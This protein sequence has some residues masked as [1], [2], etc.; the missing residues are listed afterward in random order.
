M[1][2]GLVVNWRRGRSV[3]PSW[4]CSEREMRVSA[5]AIVDG[6]GKSSYYQRYRTSACERASESRKR[7]RSFVGG[8]MERG[9]VAGGVEEATKVQ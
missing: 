6:D 9:R 8:D 2:T 3:L 1:G 4:L 5:W 7:M